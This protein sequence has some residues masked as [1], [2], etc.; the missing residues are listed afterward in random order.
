LPK[1]E[2]IV[3]LRKVDNFNLYIQSAIGC[4]GFYST[5]VIPAVYWKPTILFN[6][7]YSGLQEALND[8]GHV[9]ILDFYNFSSDDLKCPQYYMET[10]KIFNRFIYKKEKESIKSLKIILSA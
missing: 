10:D 2:N 3:Y 5:M 4:F 1:H 9:K 8:I 7:F 6:I